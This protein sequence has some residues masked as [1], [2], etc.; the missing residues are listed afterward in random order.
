MTARKTD[1]PEIK[2]CARMQMSWSAGQV[3]RSTW[4]VAATKPAVGILQS[5]LHHQ[6]LLFTSLL[7][8]QS[9]PCICQLDATIMYLKYL[10]VL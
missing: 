5:Y 9:Q 2:S 3:S 7:C 1:G 10:D 8:P 6:P 4:A